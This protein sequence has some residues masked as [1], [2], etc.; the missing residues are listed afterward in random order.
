M[1]KDLKNFNKSYFLPGLK[2]WIFLF[3]VGTFFSTFGTALLLKIRPLTQI[4]KFIWG[5]LQSLANLFPAY[6][7]GPIFLIFGSFFLVYSIISITQTS[8]KVIISEKGSLTSRERPG[9]LRA[10]ERAR[11]K[12]QGLKIVAIGGGTG[13]SNLLRGLKIFSNNL[14]AI[15][16][17]GDDGGS[18]G[19]L[20]AE[21]NLIPPGD[22]RNCIVALS[23][24]EEMITSLFQ[25]RF[26]EGTLKGHSLGNLFLVALNNI[27]GNNMAKASETACKI[28]RT[29]GKVIPACL[30][31]LSLEGELE[32]GKIIKGESQIPK[33]LEKIKRVSSQNEP[34]VHPNALEAIE[35]AQLIVIGPGSLY[36]SILPNLIIPEISQAIK[37]S[38]AK[39]I[40]V[41]NLFEDA[42]TKNYSVGDFLKAIEL[43]TDNL[44]LL[45]A[46]LINNPNQKELKYINKK[47]IAYSEEFEFPSKEKIEKRIEIISQNKLHDPKLTKH[48]SL[49]LARSLLHWFYTRT[50]S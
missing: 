19:K 4:S 43:H 17:V 6:V 33:A 49:R 29:S 8:I 39:V 41:S 27:A 44:D 2:R 40:F 36:T 14:C 50:K 46:V 32:S 25:Y 3:L 28:L 24:E 47:P 16:A 21:L 48:N 34:K 11:R 42:E 31:A 13:L 37:K 1:L 38:R 15:V 9:V 12:N 20:R 18:S 10:L 26:S 5:S 45:D 23:E 22:L 30:E 7:T 35:E